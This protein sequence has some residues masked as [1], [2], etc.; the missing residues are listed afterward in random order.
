[1]S[2][3]NYCDNNLADGS[4]FFVS[5]KNKQPWNVS[6][7]SHVMH[8]FR[9]IFST[10]DK[11]YDRERSNIFHRDSQSM[12]LTRLLICRYAILSSL[13]SPCGTFTVF[14][15]PFVLFIAS[16]SISMMLWGKPQ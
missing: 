1:M 8:F 5:D 4:A 11:R 12:F 13:V 10:N 3:D 6:D 9:N 14:I 16:S 7:R 15:D 2:S